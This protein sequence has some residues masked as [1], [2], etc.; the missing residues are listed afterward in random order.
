M[1]SEPMLFKGPLEPVLGRTSCKKQGA[2]GQSEQGHS[3]Q[4]IKD[5]KP[6]HGVL[7]S[8][9]PGV[10]GGRCQPAEPG[11]PGRRTRADGW[12]KAA[13]RG[14]STSIGLRVPQVCNVVWARTVLVWP[15]T[16]VMMTGEAWK[17]R[18]QRSL[19]LLPGWAWDGAQG[20]EEGD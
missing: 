19:G 17:P 14:A 1:Q 20:G 5:R 6:S 10:A 12:Q 8:P 16:P 15:D 18:A 9:E 7:H 11:L 13:M 3:H 4:G 2:E